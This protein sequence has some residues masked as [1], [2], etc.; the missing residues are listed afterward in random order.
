LASFAPETS[1]E[2]SPEMAP[3]DVGVLPGPMLPGTTLTEAPPLGKHARPAAR[4]SVAADA[5]ADPRLS[6]IDVDSMLA[7]LAKDK[8]P[9]L[10]GFNRRFATKTQ[11]TLAVTIGSLVMMGLA[12]ATMFVLGSF[13]H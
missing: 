6:G 2:L 1:P 3:A 10:S 4:V 13:L 7:E 5:P 9:L 8:D 11:R 12:F